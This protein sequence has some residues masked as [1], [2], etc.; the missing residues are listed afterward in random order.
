M[1]NKEINTLLENVAN[2]RSEPP[3]RFLKAASFAEMLLTVI[4]SSSR[5]RDAFGSV[6]IH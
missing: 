6:E 4:R 2:L 3:D 1:Q 5:N